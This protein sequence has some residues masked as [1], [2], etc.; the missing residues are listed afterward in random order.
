[1]RGGTEKQ[2]SRAGGDPAAW[3][4]PPGAA[5]TEKAPSCRRASR[6]GVP[7]SKGKDP[8]NSCVSGRFPPERGGHASPA[9]GLP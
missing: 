5:G 3:F 1:M 6:A 4:S 7:R 2:F 8:S 9:S